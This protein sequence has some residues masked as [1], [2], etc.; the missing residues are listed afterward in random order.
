MS[1]LATQ[2]S[3]KQP[4]S[5]C[6]K[7][8]PWVKLAMRSPLFQGRVTFG[9]TSSTTPAKSQPTV[10]PMLGMWTMC[11]LAPLVRSRSEIEMLRMR[12]CMK[13]LT[14]LLD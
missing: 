5:G 12:G 4:S 9:P 1:P 14:S 3:E 10:H 13:S 7:F 8:A 6:T 2:Y 11:C